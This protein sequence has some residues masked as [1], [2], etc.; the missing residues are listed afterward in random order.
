VERS[1]DW[2]R[3]AER[4]LNYAREASTAAYYEWACFVSQQSAEKALK[5]LYQAF[6]GE[7]WGHSILALLGGLEERMPISEELKSSARLLDRMYIP[8]RYPNG[9]DRG[10]PADYYGLN[11]AEEAIGCAASILEFVRPSIP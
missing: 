9:F 2:F 4:D 7:G 5:G 11:D 3:Q 6:A 10:I 8:T 1:R